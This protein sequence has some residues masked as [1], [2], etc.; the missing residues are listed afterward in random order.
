LVTPEGA[1][2]SIKR[3][4]IAAQGLVA[5]EITGVG[6]LEFRSPNRLWGQLNVTVGTVALSG[7]L[8]FRNDE[9]AIEADVPKVTPE[10]AR[11]VVPDWPLLQPA[12]LSLVTHGPVTALATRIQARVEQSEL[13][14][15]GTTHFSPILSGEY[16]LEGAHLDLGTW[17]GPNARSDLDLR[18]QGSFR[19]ADGQ[20]KVQFGGV[21]MPGTLLGQATPMLDFEGHGEPHELL[22]GVRARDPRLPLR[23]AFLARGHHLELDAQV[24]AVQLAPLLESFG[25]R[26]IGGMASLRTRATLEDD[27][28]TI[29]AHGTVLQPSVGPVTAKALVLDTNVEGSGRDYRT[30]KTR[31]STQFTE[32]QAGFLRLPT[33]ELGAQGQLDRF[34]IT[35]RAL[36]PAGSTLTVDT[37]VFWGEDLGLSGA[38]ATLRRGAQQMELRIGRASVEPDHIAVDALS[39]TGS[40]GSL[41][42]ALAWYDSG[43]VAARLSASKLDLAAIA[44]LL[45]LPP[46]QLAGTATA[47]LD[48]DTRG[49]AA[50]GAL[51]VTVERATV[52]I[53]S[54]V[55][56]TLEQSLSG[57]ELKGSVALSTDLADAML[58]EWDVELG[59]PLLRETSF[60]DATGR[61]RLELG[62]I[63]LERIGLLLGMLSSGLTLEGQMST[64]L[65]LTRE[66][67]GQLPSLA[68]DVL[69]DRLGV[70]YSPPGGTRVTFTQAELVGSASF[71][72]PSSRLSSEWALTQRNQP[73]LSMGFSAEVDPTPFL[74]DPGGALSA[75]YDRPFSAWAKVPRLALSDLEQ[76]TGKAIGRGTVEAKAWL[77]GP[78]TDP[79]LVVD[80][81]GE[82]LQST[83]LA[84]AL[85]LD[86]QGIFEF[87]HRTGET[88]LLCAAGSAG[89]VYARLNGYGTLFGSRNSAALGTF[90]V[91]WSGQLELGFTNLP[92]GALPK[93]SGWGLEGTVRGG[94]TVIR[95]D[96]FTRFSAILPIDGLKAQARPVGQSLLTA[97]SDDRRLQLAAKLIDG[98]AQLDLEAHLPMDFTGPIPRVRA[99]EP[100]RFAVNASGYDA[101]VLAPI[102]EP[103]FSQIQ[104][105]LSGSVEATY[106]PALPHAE[107][108][109][110]S[111]QVAIG[112]HVKLRSGRGRLRDL[113]V[114][115]TDIEL[116]AQASSTGTRTE[117]QIPHAAAA[118]GASAQ[119][120]ALSAVIELEELDLKRIGARIERAT[121]VPLVI[122]GVKQADLTGLGTVELT[123]KRDKTGP[124]REYYIEAAVQ[125]L[126]LELPRAKAR[127]VVAL[128]ENPDVVVLQPLGRDAYRKNQTTES[129]TPIRIRLLLGKRTK[130]TRSDFTLP[131]SGSPE[132]VIGTKL[133]T[134]G[135]VQLEPTGHIQLFGK[136]FVIVRGRV[137]LNPDEP[138][139]PRFEV[140]ATWRGPSHVVTATVT[141]TR[142][143]AQLRL[144]SDPPLPSE[145]QVMALLLSG[146]GS[147]VSTTT[148]GLGVGAT[149]FNEFIS[150]T[151][152]SSLELRTSQDEQHAN[153]TA[154]VPLKENLWFEGT[155]QSTPTTGLRPN[156]SAAREGFSGTVDWRFR[157]NW[158]LRTELG[159]L[160]AGADLLW[161]YRY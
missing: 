31:L 41:E 69:G 106:V 33:L 19:F 101:G 49:R 142:E 119:N 42:G 56:G 97:Q 115:V 143:T 74:I 35:G 161:Q 145:S 122:D 131:I 2:V 48:V 30:A 67:K 77:N 57:R 104:G 10:Q 138:N 150:E 14:L 160:G 125:A 15:V 109:D 139:N 85:P 89:N 82:Q 76:Y 83:A 134:T 13:E 141:G 108:E 114:N 53:L 58:G 60:R 133:K 66:G 40:A 135:S 113:G 96:G 153:Y 63:H 55:N 5:P 50:R 127:E 3:F 116:E 1:A 32:F 68:V 4:G 98:G 92:L 129:S 121:Q 36:D 152:L 11:T 25:V 158:S 159:T 16:G 120:L 94:I 147:D 18:A 65:T 61:M 137:T 64:R 62:Q 88:R 43:D 117:I 87:A 93:A 24:N 27:H 71:D 105:E 51:S 22:L 23:A 78:L 29:D 20:A 90:P 136:T 6:N 118:L 84:N 144:S 80:F 155:Y 103:Y 73:R 38:K 39:L 79:H 59:G 8:D 112:G 21:V 130:V 81:R 46:H 111:A 123:P 151:P 37:G 132:L 12:T 156:A 126:D 28:W 91:D 9:L 110:E 34:R 45:G 7:R 128:S 149:L 75:L 140:V 86:V 154:A 44:D 72:A 107:G 52:G 157:R 99:R 124:V 54:N 148:A 100:M 95:E 47:Q 146:S 70:S 26:S 102:A 17:L